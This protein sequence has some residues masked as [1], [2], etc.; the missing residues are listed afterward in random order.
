V[1]ASPR[2][3]LEP[4][5]LLAGDDHDFVVNLY[6]ALLRRWPD[7][8]GYRHFMDMVSGR[9][10]RRL[11]ALRQMAESEEVRRE[12]GGAAAMEVGPGPVVPADPRRA[13]AVALDLRTAWLREQV[14]ELR[15]AVELLGGVGGPELAG[16]G[17]E[18]IEAR[19]A[20]LRSEIAALRRET[21]GALDA[22]R[23]LLDRQG[24]GGTGEPSPDRLPPAAADPLPG[25]FADYV[26]DMIAIAEARFE[27]RL[28]ALEARTL[29]SSAEAGRP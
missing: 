3:A 23:G 11:D 24:G 29:A 25:R 15:E 21:A 19:E 10:E 22:M 26:G 20:A 8:A 18:M 5:D 7:E 9:P 1:K 28:R 6:L 4:G 16:L 17:A 2:R 13:L 12:S 14:A 27:A